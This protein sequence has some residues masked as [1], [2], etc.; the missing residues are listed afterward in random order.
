MDEGSSGRPHA[1][2][3]GP[4]RRATAGGAFCGARAEFGE[5]LGERGVQCVVDRFG[6]EVGP[7]DHE[8]RDDAE[9]GTGLGAVLEGD[10]GFVDLDQR[11]KGEQAV[12]DPVVEEIGK[13]GAGVVE[14][15]FHDGSGGWSG[16]TGE[17]NAAPT[18]RP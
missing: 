12:L 2:A 17:D 10:V 6:A 15:E 1:A 8:V 13:A 9:G 3:V 16:L 5:D 4:G 14:E 18:L 11:P 7:G